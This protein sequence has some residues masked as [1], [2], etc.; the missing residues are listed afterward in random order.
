MLGID[1][2]LFFIQA[3]FP[4]FSNSNGDKII[5]IVYIY[6]FILLSE[7]NKRMKELDIY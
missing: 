6:F 4:T 2:C 7:L 5:Q 1:E 3:Q